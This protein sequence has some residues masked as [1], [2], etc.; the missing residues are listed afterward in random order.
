AR[1]LHVAE[2]EAYPGLLLRGRIGA[3]QGEDP[4]CVLGVGRPGLLAVDDEVTLPVILGP[5]LERGEVR[6]GVGLGVALAPDLLTREYLRQKAL[7][8]RRGA[9]RDDRRPDH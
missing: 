1:R 7:L 4:V 8:L 6:P 3:H 2:K 9:E 5:G